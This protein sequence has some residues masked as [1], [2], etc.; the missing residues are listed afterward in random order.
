MEN[1]EGYADGSEVMFRDP[2]WSGSTTGVNTATDVSEVSSAQANNILP[3]AIGSTGSKSHRFFWQWNTAGTGRVRATTNNTPVRPNPAI[4]FS[5]GVSVYVLVTQGTVDFS[6]WLRDNGGSGP[7]GSN[8]G[9]SGTQIEATANKRRLTP[10]P[11]WQY[12]YFDLASE[13]ITA[14]TGNGVLD[15]A[16]GTIEA[17]VFDAVS[18]NSATNIEIF[19][20]DIYNAGPHAMEWTTMRYDTFE[21][22]WGNWASGGVDAFLSASN[23]IGA[24][25]VDLQDNSGVPSAMTMSSSMNLTGFTQLKVQFSYYPVSF[26]TGEDFWLRYSS[27]GG[28]TWTTLKAYVVGTDFTNG[29]RQQATVTTNSSAVSFTNNARIRFQCDASDNNDDVFI[30][31]VLITAK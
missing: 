9:T 21:S 7:T 11:Y 26:E 25:C 15:N 4:E 28:S 10:S 30:D 16:W 31:E 24:Q 18:G 8:G 6:L 29:V 22:G 23:A 5:R 20:D 1:F 27:N 12:I 19:V 14:V 17:F 2:A 3:P 13:P